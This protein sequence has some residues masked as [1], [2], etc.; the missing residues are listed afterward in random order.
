MKSAARR[1]ALESLGWL[2]VV[3]GIAA[4]VLPGPGLL[5]IFGGMA[6]LSQQYDWA[7]K[8]LA[9]VKKR[10]LGAAEESVET[11]PRIVFGVVCG[12]VVIG[13]GFFWGLGPDAP[14]WWPVDER[15][16]LFGGWGPGTTLIL[17]GM[18]GIGLIIYSF[19]RFRSE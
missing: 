16:W 12:L 14:G 7:E 17:S 5:M 1:I 19:R 4:L 6:I 18:I 11:W 13:L 3:A 2:L 9:P 10:A 8:R 15:W